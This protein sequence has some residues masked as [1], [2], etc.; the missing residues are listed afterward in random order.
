MRT[1]KHHA[2]A[3]ALTILGIVAPLHAQTPVTIAPTMKLQFFSNAGLP[4][5]NGC[6]SSFAAGTSNPQATYTDS[7]GTAQN[8][9]P[10]ILDAAGR[11][12]VWITAQ[13][14]KF[15]LKSA[16]GVNCA[17]GV[18]LWSEDNITGVLGLLSL[19][20]TWTGSQSFLQSVKITATTNQLILGTAP[21]LMTLNFPAPSGAKSLTF[22]NTTD[23][24][25][26]RATID[27]LTNKTLTSPTIN[28][29]TITSATNVTPVIN[30][31]STGSGVQGTDTKLLTSGTVSGTAAVLCTDANG[32]ATTTGCPG[33]YKIENVN[34]NPVTV[35]NSNV[36][37]TLMTFNLPANE[38]AANQ[39]LRL[40]GAGGILN[41]SGGAV[42][43][44]LRVYVGGNI[45][46][47][48]AAQSIPN[49]VSLGFNATV[50]TTCVTAG[51]GG[52]I[53]SHGFWTIAGGTPITG[54][55]LGN[56]FNAAT[57]AL[58]TTSAQTIKMTIQMGTA[59]PNA[60]IVERQQITERLN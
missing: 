47:T 23:T 14:Y 6:L 7:T 29:G 5:A 36:E 20:N 51:V 10:V 46:F 38:L 9:N 27:T 17:S 30:G 58:D 34:V 48:T 55:E 28:G 35:S 13:S 45:V 49:T 8:T 44:T 52:T 59:S 15:V 1:Y 12:D 25:I 22:P 32:G 2:I 43:Y 54:T 31:A 18:Q 26:G 50:L 3:I 42:N 37:T 56:N 40:W 57:F 24:M 33:N 11:A 60:S 21:N 16:G 4:L 39:T 19:P 41:T 53:E